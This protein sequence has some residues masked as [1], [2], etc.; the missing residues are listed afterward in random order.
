[1]TVYII[2]T[3][4]LI[5][6]DADKNRD[7]V[8]RKKEYIKGITTLLER[9]K[10]K[11]YKLVIVE[12]NSLIHRRLKIIRNHAT[13]LEKFGIPVIYT[14]N[15]IYRTH[16]YG[17]KELLD[18]KHVITQLNIQDDDFIVKMTGRYI[19]DKHC[20]FFDIID[21]LQTNPYSAVIRYGAYTN[22]EKERG[23]D[24][25]VTGLIGLKCKYVKDLYLP[26]DDK[27]IEQVWAE[28]IAS[29]PEEEVCTLEK[30]GIFIRPAIL[31]I[32]TLI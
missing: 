32:Y 6:E 18:I 8:T 3:S 13:F 30:L 5:N 12:N 10:G 28:K 24:N 27:F 29:L 20:P 9:C 7:Y 15:N 4:S 25:C 22:Y 11:S 23:K 31:E 21:Q 19:L 16:N 1:M 26:N 2:I 17:T 14:I